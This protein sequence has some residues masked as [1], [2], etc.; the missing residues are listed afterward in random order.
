MHKANIIPTTEVF[1]SSVV[2]NLQVCLN[3]HLNKLRLKHHWFRSVLWIACNGSFGDHMK[4]QF[5][6]PHVIVFLRPTC[7]A[8]CG[9]HMRI[10]V[11]GTTYGWQF[12]KPQPIEIL[13]TTCDWI[14]GM[15]V[16]WKWW[17]PHKDGISGKNMRWQY[18][19]PHAMAVVGTT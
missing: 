19:D 12:L 13:G 10:S 8:S 9:D 15:H 4:W 7:D 11:L 17:E 6:G 5:W 14:S 1:Q 2:S 16:R 3:F 18:L